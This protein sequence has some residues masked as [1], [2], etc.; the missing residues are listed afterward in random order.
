MFE[1]MAFAQEVVENGTSEGSG[2]ESLAK[3]RRLY[4]NRND[5]GTYGHRCQYR[6][7]RGQTKSGGDHPQ[8]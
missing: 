8:D 6:P 4:R 1:L 3:I 5:R 7:L 2:Q